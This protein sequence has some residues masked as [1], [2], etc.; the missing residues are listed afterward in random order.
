MTPYAPFV[1]ER[2]DRQMKEFTEDIPSDMLFED[3]IGARSWQF[4]YNPTSPTPISYIQGWLDHAEKYKHLIL[5]TE[6]GFDKLAKTMYGFFGSTLLFERNKLLNQYFGNGN[7][8]HFPLASMMLRDKIMLYQHDLATET[9]T[10]SSETFIWNVA[11]GYLFNYE[12]KGYWDSQDWWIHVLHEF[13]KF[14]LSKYANERLLDYEVIDRNITRSNFNTFTVI[15]NWNAKWTYWYNG[16][17]ISA[18][19]VYI[20]S[21]DTTLQAGNFTSYNG[22]VL[23]HAWQSFIEIRKDDEILIYHPWGDRTDIQVKMLESWSDEE[24]IAVFLYDKDHKAVRAIFPETEN[25]YI[26]FRMDEK[27]IRSGIKYYIIKKYTRK[28]KKG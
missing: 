18:R 19:G 14:V 3:Q 22:A 20:Q 12:V 8:E 6:L 21:H 26:L 16:H 11:F 4:D 25:G 27:F 13:Q 17:E 10:N 15:T 2:V 28:R 9:I 5:S 23:Q 24:S 1:L 7:F